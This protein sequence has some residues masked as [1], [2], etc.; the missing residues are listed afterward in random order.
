MPPR[1]GRL[2]PYQLPMQPP[3]HA[4]YPRAHGA[5]IPQP[6]R[7]QLVAPQDGGGDPGPVAGARADLGPAHPGQAALDPARGARV[8]R[9]DVQ[10]ADALAVQPEVLGEG[11]RDRELHPAAQEVPDREGVVVEGAGGEALT[12]A[13]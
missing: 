2:P 4:H 3:S 8:G 7:V 5:Q 1:A 12:D 13:A 9:D 6:L 10:R 11:L